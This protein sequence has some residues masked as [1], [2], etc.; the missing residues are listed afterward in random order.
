ML[1]FIEFLYDNSVLT[2]LLAASAVCWSIPAARRSSRFFCSALRAV[3]PGLAVAVYGPI[4]VLC[5]WNGAGLGTIL[6]TDA[7]F[8]ILGIWL[9]LALQGKSAPR[10]NA[11]FCILFLLCGIGV[12]ISPPGLAIFKP[13]ICFFQE[14][15]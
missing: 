7:V 12:V 1:K 6:V 2:V 14:R 3:P 4:P 11:L 13:R 9:T 8:L 10:R 5:F 15:M